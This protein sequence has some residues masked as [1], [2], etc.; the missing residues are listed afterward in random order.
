MLS[1]Q[2]CIPHRHTKIHR[3][4]LQSSLQH[5]SLGLPSA[6]SSGSG[7]TIAVG[8][9]S[10]KSDASS[11][12][13]ISTPTMRFSELETP[14]AAPPIAGEW[15]PKLNFSRS[16]TREE[17]AEKEFRAEDGQSVGSSTDNPYH[18][19]QPA[20]TICSADQGRY[21]MESKPWV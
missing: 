13:Q 17:P 21:P 20:S 3:T 18:S 8:E 2:H 1:L 7:S 6:R 15:L 12:T 5:V 4:N 14:Q 19:I 9:C 10:P 11:Q 16:K